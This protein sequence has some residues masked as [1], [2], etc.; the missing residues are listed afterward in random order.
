M[1]ILGLPVEPVRV[2]TMMTPL[3]PL[4]P[5]TAVAEAS[6]STDSELGSMSAK[7]RST[8]STSTSGVDPFQ[9]D[10]PR[11]KMLASLLPGCP[12]V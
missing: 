2:V 6:L 4:A 3:A 8:P 7:L 12:P 11:M 9:L 1:F 10:T 5:N